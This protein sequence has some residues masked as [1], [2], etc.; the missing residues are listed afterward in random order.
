M[1]IKI[2]LR[3]L[4]K[5]LSQIKNQTLKSMTDLESEEQ[6][7]AALR[8]ML[9][10]QEAVIKAQRERLTKG[11]VKDILTEEDLARYQTQANSARTEKQEKA[12]DRVIS[13]GD[14]L[15][16]QLREK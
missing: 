13:F 6:R 2:I 16:T 4:P 9:E 11:G 1:A 8:Q 3:V 7:L 14:K 15:G 5:M 10:Q 12:K